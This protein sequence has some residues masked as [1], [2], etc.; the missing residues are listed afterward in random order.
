[1]KMPTMGAVGFALLLMAGGGVSP[2]LAECP[3]DLNSDNEVSIDEVLLSVLSALQGCSVPRFI[4]NGNGTVSDQLTGLMWEQKTRDGGIHAL[5][6][7]TWSRN[8]SAPDGTAFTEFLPALND[9]TGDEFTGV[10]G[11]FAGHC[12]WRLPTL[13]ELATI[14]CDDDKHNCDENGCIDLVFGE[15]SCE[16]FWTSSGNSRDASRAWQLDFDGLRETVE[17]VGT[18]AVRAVRTDLG[19]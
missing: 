16:S 15:P 7:Y 9:C 12:D 8:G 5:R 18:A 14:L 1:M 19:E 17:K 2:G 10:R 4:D 11:G 13:G 3:G 6:G